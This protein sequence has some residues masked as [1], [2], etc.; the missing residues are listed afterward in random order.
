[1]TP[2]DKKDAL[3]II[4]AL[5]AAFVIT[6][7]IY[8]MR[9]H[10]TTNPDYPTGNPGSEIIVDIPEGA[11]GSAIAKILYA[12][13]VVRSYGA[14]FSLAVIDPRSAQIA[15]GAHRLNEHISAKE[16]LRQLL[17]SNRIFNL[18]R[19]P[20][21]AWTDE[22]LL[23]MEKAGFARPDLLNALKQIHRP[24]GFSGNEGVFF[25]AQYSFGATTS[26]IAALQSMV[27]RFQIEAKA[28]GVDQGDR[29]FNPMQLLT[30]ASIVQAEGDTKDF[31]KI[32]QVIRNRL[33][34]DMP[35]QLDTTV[36]YV[37]RT[38]GQV[39]LSTDAT[40]TASLY[41][42]YLHYGLPPGPI[43]NPGRAALDASL[44]PTFGNW[45]YF[46]T[47]APGDTRFTDSDSQF[48][49]WKSLYEKNLAAG[50]FGKTP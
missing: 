23:L 50:A 34:L 22:I 45:I 31:S 27:D 18:I 42:T 35:L 37:T 40:Q 39:F 7:G 15:P 49:T 9:S 6:G 32:S 5:A 48:L 26:A 16:A 3:R 4:G 41:N 20:E 13:L 19:I 29:G 43:G 2:V 24:I 44:H 11:T 47:V 1:V 8:L 30:I 33:K 21:G 10:T 12:K 36:H 38:R 14:F 17:D 46:I 25:P 28:S